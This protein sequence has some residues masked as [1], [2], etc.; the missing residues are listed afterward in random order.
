MGLLFIPVISTAWATT[1][2]STLGSPD[3]TITPNSGPPGT[4]ITITVSNLPD[5]SKEQYPYPELY[6][7]LPFSQ[8]F[9]VTVASHCGGQDCLPVYTYDDALNHNAANRT[10]T[11]SLFSTSNPSPVYL[12]GFEN[13]VCD[14]V[15]NGKT[16]ER[17]STICNT[18]DEPIGTYQIK[19]A[20]TLESDF[21]QTY[22]EKVLQFTVTPGSPPPAPQVAENGDAIIKQYQ[23]GEI[24]EA[25]FEAK[26]KAL[27]WN[28]E[29]I[30]QAL[31]VIGKLHQAGA[32]VP[33]QMQ[34]IQQGVQKAA[35]QASS[36]PTE[37]ATQ[38]T[39]QEPYVQVE[40]IPNPYSQQKPEQPTVPVD[41]SA[42]SSQQNN[43]SWNIIT[44]GATV[45][46]AAA[47]VGGIFA[48]KTRKV[49]N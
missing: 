38:Q 9:G 43:P 19:L 49:R 12:N 36:Q 6:I 7:Y 20:W 42:N 5:I 39:A 35:E 14:I 26:L 22:T 47:I 1:D 33:E 32:P 18:K 30:R 37:Q 11:F 24:S 28:D 4:K 17:F 34:Q 29:Q 41:T 48:V 3:V 13:S 31:A 44:I 46:A 21:S 16:L 45:G 25:Q 40:T 23:N 10:I 15:M 27:G 8:A 2:L